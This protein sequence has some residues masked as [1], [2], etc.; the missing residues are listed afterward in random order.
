MHY[1]T[2]FGICQ[3]GMSY[4]PERVLSSGDLGKGQYTIGLTAVLREPFTGCSVILALMLNH[5]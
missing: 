4:K 5:V 1:N 3:T 2:I